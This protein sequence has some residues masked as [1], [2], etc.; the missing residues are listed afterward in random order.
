METSS[1]V[2]DG[3]NNTLLAAGSGDSTNAD[4]VN[5]GDVLLIVA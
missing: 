4:A 2:D 3:D 1:R 5:A